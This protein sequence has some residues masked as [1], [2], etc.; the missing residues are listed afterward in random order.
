MAEEAG[1]AATVASPMGVTVV[2]V[3]TEV[4]DSLP[5]GALGC[6]YNPTKHPSTLETA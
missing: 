1:A 6:T 2:A 3:A 5:K 4:P